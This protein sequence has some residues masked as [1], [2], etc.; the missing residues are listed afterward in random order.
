VRLSQITLECPTRFAPSTDPLNDGECDIRCLCDWQSHETGELAKD[1][2]AVLHPECPVPHAISAPDGE[3]EV[4]PEEL[5]QAFKVFGEGE[6][7][8]IGED[9]YRENLNA[10]RKAQAFV[11]DHIHPQRRQG[12]GE[13]PASRFSSCRGCGRPY[14]DPGFPD[15]IVP[16]DVWE[17]I[18]PS[19]DSGGLL[20]PAC[21]IAVIT[22]QEIETIA[23]FRSGPLSGQ[24]L[25]FF[26]AVE[27]GCEDCLALEVVAGADGAVSLAEAVM[28]AVE[29]RQV[30]LDGEDDGY[31]RGAP[32][33]Y[34]GVSK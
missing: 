25:S 2:P 33:N 21:I 15:L 17:R 10:W 26:R 27:P 3:E 8:F 24:S 34:E 13:V 5:E 30:E 32:E 7:H 28:D 16:D 29:Q 20:C 4:W 23:T 9:D 11:A 19:G 12:E 18:S 22:E 31:G 6:P 14:S 1:Y